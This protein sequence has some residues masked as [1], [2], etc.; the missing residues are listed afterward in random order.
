MLYPLSYGGGD[1]TKPGR[2]PSA[3]QVIGEVMLR[4]R[5]AG[6]GRPRV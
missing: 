4:E 5:A 6:P 1:C 2:K 3:V